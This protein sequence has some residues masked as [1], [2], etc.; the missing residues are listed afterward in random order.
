MAQTKTV[1]TS[2]G[3]LTVSSLVLSDLREL[4]RPSPADSGK[5]SFEFL[6]FIARSVRKVHQNISEQQL[7]DSLLVNEYNDLLTAVFEV[8][9][10]KLEKKPAGEAQAP[11]PA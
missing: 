7:A 2:L 4:E 5:L 3:P 10:M 6:P 9:N 11:A 1:N 8:S